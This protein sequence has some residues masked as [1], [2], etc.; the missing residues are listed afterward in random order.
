META[1]QTPVPRFCFVRELVLRKQLGCY[2]CQPA[3]AVT[4]RGAAEGEA[5]AR[6]PRQATR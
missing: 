4:G 2:L 3:A 6:R 5:A 1:E